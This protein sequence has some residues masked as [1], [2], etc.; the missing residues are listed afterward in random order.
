MCFVYFK[1]AF[2]YV[3]HDALWITRLDMGF[4]AHLVN[5]IMRLY[6]RHKVTVKTAGVVSGWFSV[7]K[8]VRQG[9]MLSPHLFNIQ[10]TA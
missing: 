9:C 2:D 5:L 4:P 7:M 1:K 6:K 3:P 8:G 10:Y